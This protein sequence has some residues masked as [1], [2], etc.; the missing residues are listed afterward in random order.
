MTDTELELCDGCGRGCPLSAPTCGLG[1]EI[2]QKRAHQAEGGEESKG[3]E[4]GEGRESGDGSVDKLLARRFHHCAHL[5]MYRRAKEGGR[6]RA[7]VALS[8]HGAMSQRELAERL[9]IRSASASELLTKMEELGLVT[10]T[11]DENDRRAMLVEL[12]E[13]GR[14]EAARIAAQ[15]EKA[16][17]N[18]FAVLTDEEKQQ[19]E[20]ILGK[21]T[22]YW[23]EEFDPESGARGCRGGRGGRHGHD[24]HDEGHGERGDHDGHGMHGDHSARG[25]RSDHAHHGGRRRHA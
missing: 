12:T 24:G 19:L 20:S 6:A 17:K 22:P 11:P 15:R 8:H 25:D 1:F 18:L 9:N 23:H 10:R 13:H 7:L 5:L 14:Q 3:S 21:L 16:D 2:A 4:G